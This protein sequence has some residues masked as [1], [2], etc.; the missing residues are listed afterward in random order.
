MFKSG[1]KQVRVF[2]SFSHVLETNTPKSHK[3]KPGLGFI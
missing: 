1:L 2:A 3:P